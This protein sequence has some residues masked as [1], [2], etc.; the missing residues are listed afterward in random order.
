MVEDLILIRKIRRGDV[1][2]FETLFR[3][4]YSPLVLYSTG[5]TGSSEAA[6]DIIQEL[7]YSIWK[8]RESLDIIISVKAYLYKSVRNNSLGSL[9]K[10]ER[11]ANNPEHP[12]SH[13]PASEALGNELK[14]IIAKSISSMPVRRAEIFRMHRFRDLK[15]KEIAQQ[16]SLSVKTVELEMSKALS[17][18]RKEIELYHHTS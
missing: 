2:A 8:N 6:E 7:F 11:R 3:K 1:A 13:D 10:N 9:Q 4:F 12:D 16:L 14:E 5:I 18:L 15:Y 17:T